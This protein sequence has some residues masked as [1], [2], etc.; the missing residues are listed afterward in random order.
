MVVTIF[1]LTHTFQNKI[2]TIISKQGA[3][4]ASYTF[5]LRRYAPLA[6]CYKSMITKMSAVCFKTMYFQ[7]YIYVNA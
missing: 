5:G 6:K 7:V 1:H 2:N 3:D 4:L